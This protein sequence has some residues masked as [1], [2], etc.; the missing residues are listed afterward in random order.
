MRNALETNRI[1]L[2]YRLSQEKDKVDRKEFLPV[3]EEARKLSL[4]SEKEMTPEDE[5][6]A[7]ATLL[8]YSLG[9][10]A[11]AKKEG[12]PVDPVVLGKRAYLRFEIL[13]LEDDDFGNGLKYYDSD[14]STLSAL[15]H[16]L[17]KINRPA[18]RKNPDVTLIN[19][20]FETVFEKVSGFSG[21]LTLGQYAD[22]FTMWRTFHESECILTLLIQGGEKVRQTYVLHLSY[23]NYLQNQQNF[24]PEFLDQKFALIKE[25]MKEHALVAKDMKKFIEYGWIYSAP[26]YDPN[27]HQFR[28]NFL[29]GVE[30]LS[31]LSAYRRIYQGSSEITHSSSMFFYVNNDFCRQLALTLVYSCLVDI[32][33]LYLTYMKAYFD[34]NPGQ[35]ERIVSLLEDVKKMAKDFDE[36]LNLKELHEDD[37]QN[38]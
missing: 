29:D 20:L 7:F 16:L 14:V 23:N 17:E 12:S 34:Y 3:F 5:V 22:C 35:R 31:G 1:L 8:D 37:D 10:Y 15:S 33:N 13:Y 4:A 26:N 21:L 19:D 11:K 6:Y 30:R 24:T 27:D 25:Q 38:D 9:E 28:L 36:K 18:S 32:S 2:D